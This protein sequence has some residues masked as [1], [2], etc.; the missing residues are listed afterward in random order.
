MN[1]STPDLDETRGFDA[2]NFLYVDDP[3]G[4]IVRASERDDGPEPMRIDAG[5]ETSLCDFPLDEGLRRTIAWYAHT[6]RT[7]QAVL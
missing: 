5:Q 2:R 3:A 1:D 6:R 4:A 7:R